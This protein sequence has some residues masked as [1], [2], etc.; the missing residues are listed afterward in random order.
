MFIRQNLLKA[1]LND[2]IEQMPFQ[3]LDS[4]L[5]SSKWVH[6]E[7]GKIWM[8]LHLRRN[9]PFYDVVEE[10]RESLAVTKMPEL[11]SITEKGIQ[12]SLSLPKDIFAT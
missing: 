6:I 12:T 7:E 2:Y 5:T 4:C 8:M 3:S 1:R 11:D 9:L 10:F